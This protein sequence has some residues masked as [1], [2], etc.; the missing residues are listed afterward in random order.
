MKET[1]GAVPQRA[2]TPRSGS[3]QGG[4]ATRAL[5]TGARP[6]PSVAGLGF[7]PEEV[8]G[9]GGRR[10]G[11]MDLRLRACPFKEAVLA[12]GGHLICAL[13]RGLVRGALEWIDDKAESRGPQLSSASAPG[14]W[15]RSRARG[16]I[17]GDGN[18]GGGGG[19]GHAELD[20]TPVS[21]A[22]LVDVD[23]PAHELMHGAGERG[24]ILAPADTEGPARARISLDRLLGLRRV[25]FETGEDGPGIPDP[26]D[27]N[28][29]AAL[30]VRLPASV[31]ARLPQIRHCPRSRGRVATE[32]R[33][34]APNR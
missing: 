18:G 19:P 7:A 15:C 16:P 25:L 29:L 14:R 34:A 26:S 20:G 2:A 30:P 28:I 13:H 33:R 32:P 31:L 1:L 17:G 24:D 5:S 12:E 4:G 8:T 23:A 11:Q 21:V 27:R 9:E 22:A 6:Q 3:D 10:A